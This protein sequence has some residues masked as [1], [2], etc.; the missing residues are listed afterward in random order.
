MLAMLAAQTPENQ[1]AHNASFLVTEVQFHGPL[2]N[3]RLLLSPRATP[4]ISLYPKLLVNAC[5]YAC[6]WKK[7]AIR[8]PVLPHSLQIT[9]QPRPYQKILASILVRNIS[10]RNGI[11]SANAQKMAIYIS[12]MSPLRTMLQTFSQSHFPHKHFFVF[13]LS[14]ACIIGP[15]RL[16]SRRRIWGPRSSRVPHSHLPILIYHGL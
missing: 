14:L 9:R 8:N 6:S 1:L 16:H 15:K 13:D 11:T 7:L 2:G 4:N 10:I 3:K 12:P 5:G